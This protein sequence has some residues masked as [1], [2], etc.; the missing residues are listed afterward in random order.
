LV[1]KEDIFNLIKQY[2]QENLRPLASDKVPVSGKVYNEKELINGVDALLKGWWTEGEYNEKLEKALSIYLGIKHSITVNSGSSANLLALST[3]TS[4]LIPKE[5]RL[6]KDDEIITV[7]AGFPTTINP[8]LQCGAIPVFLDAELATYSPDLSLLEEAVSEKT[9]AVFFAHTLGN[10]FDIETVKSFTHKRGIWFIEDNCD[11]LGSEYNGQK[12]GSFGDIA[13]S[14]FYPAHHITTAEGG[15]IYTNNSTLKRIVLSLRDWGRDCWCKTG[16]DNTCKNR[17]NQQF[18]NLPFGYDHKYV[19]SHIGYNLKLT[20]LQ[21]A[22]GLAQIEKLDNFNII[23][24][25]NF[26]FLT[27]RMLEEKLDDYFILPVPTKKSN[28][29]WFGY[30]LTVNNKKVN[31]EKLMVYLN[32]NNVATRLLFGGN[33]VK[34]PYFITNNIKYKIIGNLKNTDRIMN[35]TFWMGLYPAL[36]ENHLEYSIQT[37]KKFIHID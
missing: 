3:F 24:R 6:Q 5:S 18:G 11:S 1:T 20:D 29:S 14:S 23:R 34:Q 10:P 37:L 25:K 7:A 8:I 22:I 15:A 12:T 16:V 4:H 21:A 26:A 33:L 32:Q 2:Y 36:N 30:P 27:K 31:R 19:Y 17:F 9:R 13:T 35:D 28:P